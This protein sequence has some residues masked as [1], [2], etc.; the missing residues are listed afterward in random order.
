MS[1]FWRFRNLSEEEAELLLYGEIASEQPWWEGGD[2]VTPKQFY[3]DLKAL[4]PKSNITVRINSAGGDVFAA[5]AIYTQLKTNAAKVTVIVDGLAAS[6]A[7]I[8]AM[9]GDIVK[10]PANAMMMIHNPTIGLLGY[11]TAEEME[12]FAE[13]LEAVKESIINAYMSKTGLDRKTLSKMMDK[14]TWMTGEE[15]VEKG[16]A[17]EV[18]FQNVQMSIRGSLLIVNS[19]SHDLSRFKSRPP[20]PEIKNG[21]VPKDVSRETAP[22]DETWEAPNLEDFTDKSWDELSDDEKRRIAGHYAWAPKMPPDRFSDLKLP[23]HRPSD[24]AVVWAGVANAAARLPQ[25]DIPDEDLEEV[26]DH[27]GSHYRQFGRTPPWER[28]EE[29]SNAWRKEEQELKLEIKTVD[30]LR[31]HFPELVAQLEAAAREEGIKAERQRIQAIDEI[32]RTLAP[33]LVKKAKYEQ[34]MTAEQLALEALKAEA[35]KGR[36]YLEDLRKDNEESGALSIKGQPYRAE[37]NVANIAQTIAEYANK[38]RRMG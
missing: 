14:E 24:G 11:Y 8:V 33:E 16:F 2:L 23:H 3:E 36:Q 30:E 26:Q 7:S 5:Q 13:Q 27:L 12:K 37:S 32:S 17:D 34:P 35:A 20:V 18:L 21:V 29:K 25:T 6:A 4:G 15:A 9:A 31:E 22:E 10:M 28:D 19:I 38:R 1:K